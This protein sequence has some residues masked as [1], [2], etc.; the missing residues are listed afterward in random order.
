MSLKYLNIFPDF[1]SHIGKPLDKKAK[2]DIKFYD[3]IKWEIN[4]Y[5]THIAQY[6]IK[7]TQLVDITWEICFFRNHT[8]NELRKLVPDLFL[9]FKKALHEVKTSGQHLNFNIFW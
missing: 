9:F 8:E 4:N 7:F 2:V 1:F 3:V 5:N 6:L